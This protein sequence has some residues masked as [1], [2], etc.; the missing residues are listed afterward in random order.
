MG[1]MATFDRDVSSRDSA[2]LIFVQRVVGPCM[3]QPVY[4]DTF[5]KCLERKDLAKSYAATQIRICK[6]AGASMKN[7]VERDLGGYTSHMMAS[8]FDGRSAYARFFGSVKYD[9]MVRRYT[10]QC[11]MQIGK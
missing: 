10:D 9:Q 6:C 3:F 4:E 11:A 2:T 8:D 1:D 5:D 7:F